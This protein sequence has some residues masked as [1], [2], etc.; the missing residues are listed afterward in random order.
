MDIDDEDHGMGGADSGPESE[1]GVPSVQVRPVY[2]FHW[3]RFIPIAL[4]HIHGHYRSA[5]RRDLRSGFIRHCYRAGRRD[6]RR[7]G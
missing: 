6:L 2:S 5:G 7:A 3:H 4:G 1:E